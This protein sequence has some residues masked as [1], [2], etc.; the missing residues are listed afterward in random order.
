MQ[1]MTKNQ[2]SAWVDDLYGKVELRWKERVLETELMRRL[3]AGTLPLEALAFLF[4]HGYAQYAIEINTL[5]GCTYQ[6]FLPFF[7]QHVDLMAA[8]GDKIADEYLHPEPPG[9]ALI[10]F[11]TCEALGVSRQEVLSNPVLPELRGL[12]DLSRAILYEGTAAE[13][14]ARAASEKMVGVWTGQ[15]CQALAANY[16]FTPEQGIYFSK[17]EEADLQEHDQGVMGHGEFNAT[18]LVRLLE[19][20]SAW[21]RPGY[22]MEYCALANADLWALM[23]DQ[24]LALF[25]SRQ[26]VRA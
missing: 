10:L 6:K 7:K 8:V 18:V 2:A 21:E 13:W 16:G 15:C 11:Q 19:T 20:G 12:I 17:H 14:F 4:R 1:A 3:R 23:F 9:H 26:L 22:G 25:E 5:W 24:A